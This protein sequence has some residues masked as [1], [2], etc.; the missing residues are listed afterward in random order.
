MC[1]PVVADL[2]DD[3][4]D[5]PEQRCVVGEQRGDTGTAF[6]LVVESIGLV[7]GSQPPSVSDWKGEGSECFGD[8][9]LEPA[10]KSGGALL[11]AS[12]GILESPIGLGGILG[13]DDAP[14]ILNHLGSY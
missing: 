14:D 12:D 10:G 9:V 5:E 3:C 8:V 11:V 1:F 13:V 6:D 4:R 7:A 2:A